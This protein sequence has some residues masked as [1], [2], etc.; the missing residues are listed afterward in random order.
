[1]EESPLEAHAFGEATFEGAVHALLGHHHAGPAHGA[2]RLGSGQRLGHQMVG[3]HHARHQARAF[4]FRR[5]H[6]AAGQHHVHGL[7]L[8]HR[9]R[10]PLRAT[11]AGDDA[12]LDLGL[13]E[14]RRVGGDDEVA[15]HR[16][17]TAAAQ[18]KA[19]HRGNHRFAHAE[20][21][22]PVAGDEVAA[23]GFVEGHLRDARDVGAG[24]EG[25]FAAGDDDAADGVVGIKDQQRGA[26]LVHQR[27]VQ[28]IELLGAVQ[29]DEAGAAAAVA[30]NVGQDK[31]V[32]H[33]GFQSG[34][35]LGVG[36][37]RPL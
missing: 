22:L 8:A 16:Q 30:A 31:G 14:A 5:V 17:F 20:D 23:I 32:G 27:I 33:G 18:R 3:C 6:R 15:H 34:W 19:G 1:M 4:G 9:T 28:R 25:L 11:R 7:A 12:E 21:R 35:A 24:S 10:Q 37:S 13:T 26:Q 29:R 36:V 2:H